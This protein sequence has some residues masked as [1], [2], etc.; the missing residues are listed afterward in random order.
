MVL[1]HLQAEDTHA[2]AAHCHVFRNVERQG[3]FSHGGPACNDDEVAL[4]KSAGELVKLGEPAEHPADLSSV[5]GLQPGHDFLDK[6]PQRLHLAVFVALGDR[7]DAV[8]GLIE[9]R[10]RIIA[11]VKGLVKNLTGLLNEPADHGLFA[12]QPG[13]VAGVGGA[14][15]ATGQL[16]Q[17]ILPTNSV[18]D[19]AIHQHL[20]ELHDI[21]G[22]VGVVQLDHGVVDGS[23][24]RLVE[25]LAVSDDQRDVAQLARLKQYR[26]QKAHLGFDRVR[27]K[28]LEQPG[29]TLRV[30]AW[31]AASGHW[32]PQRVLRGGSCAH[33]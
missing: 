14:G 33:P 31:R 32:R 4:L 2:V 26:A 20:V 28:L 24:G 15:H 17:V 11:A 23:V 13:V 25:V 1:A 18:Q 19:I 16:H 27:G 6:A 12:D 22:R 21:E 29:D 10:R 8:L 30:A 3:S 5:A 9:N 7:E